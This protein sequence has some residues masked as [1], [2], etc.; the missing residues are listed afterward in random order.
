[1][2]DKKTILK[3]TVQLLCFSL[4]SITA[5]GQEQKAVSADTAFNQRDIIDMLRPLFFKNKSSS[6]KRDSGI[7]NKKIYFSLLPA[8]TGIPGGGPG[9]PAPTRPGRGSGG[10]APGRPRR[11]AGADGG[12]PRRISRGSRGGSRRCW[13]R[14]R[15]R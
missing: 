14:P 3:I 7:S 6:A 1:M 10:G 4:F 12:E 2:N 8:S 11:R 9:G 5:I 13:A 15:R